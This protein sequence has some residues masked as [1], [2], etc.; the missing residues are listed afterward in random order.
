M[1]ID[2]GGGTLA[3]R[4]RDPDPGE[5]I[6]VKDTCEVRRWNAASGL[7]EEY[8]TQPQRNLDGQLAFQILDAD[9][10]YDYYAK[11]C[12]L[13]MAQWMYDTKR[14]RDFLDPTGVPDQYVSLLAD[15]FGLGITYETPADQKREFIRQF[16]QIQ[17]SKGTAGSFVQALRMLGYTGYANNIWVIP[18]GDPS[19]YIEKPIG[20]DVGP[21][22]TY[23]PAS[24]VSIHLND[25]GG[26]PL[27]VIDD[28]IKEEVAE[29]LVLNVLP[30]H[31]RIR[32]FATDHSV[33]S[34]PEGVT[35]ADSLAISQV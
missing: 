23:Y 21:P 31:V 11:L 34:E 1:V 13:C 30:A 24:Q 14:L 9:G 16:I 6:V 33:T 5:V 22:T 19:A 15:N 20:Y 26:D 27:Q 28:A 7:W 25:L 10:V 12:G 3:L 2:E 8:R 35:V 29:F 32:Y 4:F 18:G 17:K